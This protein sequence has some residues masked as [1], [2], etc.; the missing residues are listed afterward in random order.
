MNRNLYKR[1]MIDE[2]TFLAVQETLL[3]KIEEL[4]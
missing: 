2:E 1:E 3:K 4:P